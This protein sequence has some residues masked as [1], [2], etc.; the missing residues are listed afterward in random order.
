[1]SF[2]HLRELGRE[3]ARALRTAAK[4]PTFRLVAVATL[5]IGIGAA[6]RAL[7]AESVVLAPQ[8]PNWSGSQ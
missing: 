6:R 5:A 2:D 7:H 1:M 8:R 3:V 4:R